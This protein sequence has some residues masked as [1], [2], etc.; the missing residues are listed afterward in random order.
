[1]H[2]IYGGSRLGNAGALLLEIWGEKA[3]SI[4][5]D[6]ELG[7]VILSQNAQGRLWPRL[8]IRTLHQESGSFY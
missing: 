7:F 3:V 5:Y 4:H 2:V 8:W 6:I 1:M